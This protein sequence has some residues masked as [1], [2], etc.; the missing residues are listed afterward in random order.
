MNKNKQIN[1]QQIYKKFNNKSKIIT[2]F[3]LVVGFLA[4]TGF[5]ISI[6]CIKNNLI[7]VL[8]SVGVLVLWFVVL[9]TIASRLNSK[10][11]ILYEA[12]YGK[13]NDFICSGLFGE[14]WEEFEWNQFEGLT[15]GKVV[16]AE[17][18]NNTIEIE[19]IRHKHEFNIEIDKDGVYM[20]MDEETDIPVE[21][22]IPLVEMNEV[23]QVFTA[24][25]E[26]VESV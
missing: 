8:I 6:K 2:M 19:I 11:I 7:P 10:R 3:I 17:A 15:D 1:A 24:I 20:V 16:F 21:K 18:H 9:C 12:A 25:R 5:L 26:F 22:E 14:I 4:L 23:G 13:D